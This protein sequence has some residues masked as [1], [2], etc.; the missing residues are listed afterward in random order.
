MVF[1]RRGIRVGC[2]V[3]LLHAVNCVPEYLSFEDVDM[4]AVI[5]H[6]LGGSGEMVAICVNGWIDHHKSGTLCRDDF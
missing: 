2:D 3:R 6:L 1:E 4:H 5:A